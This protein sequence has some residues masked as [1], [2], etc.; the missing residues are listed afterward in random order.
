MQQTLDSFFNIPIKNDNNDYISP[1][2]VYLYWSHNNDKV[3]VE[4]TTCEK[5]IKA[6]FVDKISY[7]IDKKK[8][9]MRRM[10]Y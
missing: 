5:T 8:C 6:D 4:Y 3:C 1:S 7:K 10:L 2:H 9:Q